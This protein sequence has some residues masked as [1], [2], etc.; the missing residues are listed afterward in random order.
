MP[1][2]YLLFMPVAVLGGV[3]VIVLAAAALVSL[4]R[5][6]CLPLPARVAWAT[7]IVVL[8]LLGPLAWL[9]FSQ[10]R[11]RRAS[12]DAASPAPAAEAPASAASAAETRP[13]GRPDPVR[14][15]SA[16][17]AEGSAAAQDA[18]P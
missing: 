12:A 13:E 7:A 17:E 16:T 6:A 9:G 8:P 1:I 18:M 4:V 2:E 15:P 11:D 14:G 10:F 3:L 5:A